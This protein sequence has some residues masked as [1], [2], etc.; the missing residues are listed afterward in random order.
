[1]AADGAEGFV[2]DDMLNPAG[3]LGRG[4]FVHPQMDQH[5]PD[6]RM[7]LIYLFRSLPAQFRQGQVAVLIRSQ[8]AALLQKSHAPA[9]A[10]LGK[11][12]IFRNIDGTDIG[13]FLCENIDVFLIHFT[14]FLQYHSNT[15]YDC[16]FKH[17]TIPG[18]YQ[19]HPLR[20][21]VF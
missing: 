12:H 9:D 21:R 1:M 10:G 13:A 19:G 8:I 2:A 14:G 11:S 15:S 7:P 5:I 4:F 6:D 20:Q 17:T 16:F 18:D 3:I